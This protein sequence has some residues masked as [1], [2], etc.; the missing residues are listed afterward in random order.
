M[1]RRRL[2]VV[3]TVHRPD[4]ARIRSKL[5]P[6]LETEWDVWFACRAPGPT[7]ADGLTWVPLTGGRLRRGF[8]AARTMLAKQWDLVAVHDPEL[9][10][11]AMLR[12]LLGRPTLFDLHENLPGQIRHKGRIPLVLRPLISTISKAILRLAGR[13]MTITVAEDGYLDLVRK[14]AV[15]IP[16][17][18]VDDLPDLGS[19]EGFLAYVGDVTLERGADLALHAAAGA[20]VPLVMVGRIAPP[21]LTSELTARARELGVDLELVGA[22]PHREA[23]GRIAHAGAGLSPLLDVPN[24]RHSL[25]TKVLEYLALGLPV[26]VSDLPG[27]TEVVTGL[28]GV[29]AVNPGDAAAWAAAGARA[30]DPDLR[31]RAQAQAPAVRA[32]FAWDN[33]TVLGA[34]RDALS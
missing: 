7:D 30:T 1:T 27:T 5:I 18:L 8:S 11:A 2:L 3:T 32:R 26:L 19:S 25:P 9:I 16:N 13:M 20:G 31:R 6:T 12:S 24:Y 22:L 33:E 21:G 28:E 10:P 4:D 14:P 29:I 15:V 34:Y 17:H 23:M